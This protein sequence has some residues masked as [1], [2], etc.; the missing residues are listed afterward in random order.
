MSLTPIV[1]KQVRDSLFNETPLL[2]PFII[3]FYFFFFFFFFFLLTLGISGKTLSVKAKCKLMKHNTCLVTRE[4]YGVTS[5]GHLRT[6]RG[7]VLF[8]L[9]LI[10][11]L[12]NTNA[13]LKVKLTVAFVLFTQT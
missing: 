5:P 4:C 8:L 2:L 3:F 13:F 10:S 7:N 6:V 12:R 11:R 9:K 1:R